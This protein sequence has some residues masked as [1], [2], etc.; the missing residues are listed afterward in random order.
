M[1][2][3]SGGSETNLASITVDHLNLPMKEEPLIK[4][5]QLTV[6]CPNLTGSSSTQGE[7]PTYLPPD[8]GAL[9]SSQNNSH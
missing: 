5:E 4:S 8:R 3:K 7:T 9:L 2:V 6:D 1:Q